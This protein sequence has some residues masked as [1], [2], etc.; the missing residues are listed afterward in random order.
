MKYLKRLHKWKLKQ[1]HERPVLWCVINFFKGLAVGLLAYH[2][3][4]ADRDKSFPEH[5]GEPPAI[6]TKDYRPLPCGYGYGS[7]TLHN[8][9]IK[10]SEKDSKE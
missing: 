4:I 1:I 9:I 10:N 5:W 3:L 2:F 6:Q 7:S 8:W